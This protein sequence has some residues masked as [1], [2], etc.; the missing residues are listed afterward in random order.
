MSSKLFWAGALVVLSAASRAGE[1][2]ETPLR[3]FFASTGGLEVELPRPNAL[4]PVPQPARTLGGE[5]A[6]WEP[7]PGPAAQRRAE[8]SS[9]PTAPPDRVARGFAI[10]DLAAPNTALPRWARGVAGGVAE[11][12]SYG[13]RIE[14]GEGKRLLGMAGAGGSPV[15]LETG[16][17]EAIQQ[18][19]RSLGVWWDGMPRLELEFGFTTDETWTPGVFPDSFTVGVQNAAGERLYVVT[20]DA[21]GA[22]WAPLVPDAVVID[23]NDILWS[24]VPYGAADPVL[25][26]ALAYRVG[27]DLP[28]GWSGQELT[29]WFELVD[30]QDAIRSG[31]YFSHLTLVPE[32][33]GPALA[34]LDGLVL[35]VFLRRC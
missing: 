34:A 19:L 3:M 20:T 30:N 6:V 21:S 16:T 32:P 1:A 4:W 2:G 28:A 24:T 15:V 18:E 25:A 35:L 29:A 17:G 12:S 9:S 11:K 22:L 14:F 8:T 5:P 13:E 33:G 10:P 26:M 7:A 23:V 27:L 31:A